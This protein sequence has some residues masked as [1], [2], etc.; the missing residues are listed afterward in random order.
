MT[1]ILTQ[2]EREAI[3]AREQAATPGY[4][5]KDRDFSDIKSDLMRSGPNVFIASVTSSHDDGEFIAHSKTDIPNLL[6]SCDELE[7]RLKV[8]ED[9]LLR[10]ARYCGY[11]P[12]IEDRFYDLANYAIATLKETRGEG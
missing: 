12:Y 11:G 4:W 3:R 6:D 10:V 1:P 7:R 2:K 5:Y 9:A 8:A